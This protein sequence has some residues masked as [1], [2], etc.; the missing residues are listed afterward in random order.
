[1]EEAIQTV[2]DH[3][4]PLALYLFTEDKQVEHEVLTRLTA[5][6]SSGFGKFCAKDP[7]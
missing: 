6:N 4:K 1:M 2:M 7:Y 5:I 3:L